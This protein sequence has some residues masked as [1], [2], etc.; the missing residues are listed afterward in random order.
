[1]TD[2]I[3]CVHHFIIP[4]PTGILEECVGICKL[5]GTEQ[6]MSNADAPRIWGWGRRKDKTTE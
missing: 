3:T 2:D 5:C 4:P 1:M 6:P